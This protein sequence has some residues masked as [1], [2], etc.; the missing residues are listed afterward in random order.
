M[1]LE[2]TEGHRRREAEEAR[3]ALDE[4]RGRILALEK[5]RDSCA[6]DIEQLKKE[7][8]RAQGT[9]KPSEDLRQRLST[10]EKQI[11]D[12]DQKIREFSEQIRTLEAGKNQ[13]LETRIRKD[14]E[15]QM[16]QRDNVIVSLKKQLAELG[17][18]E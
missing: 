11:A 13:E 5:E 6:I 12:R 2:K 10:A 9:G 18:E 1:D 16:A 15:E 7:L 3:Q 14:Y 8:S 17:R 4:A